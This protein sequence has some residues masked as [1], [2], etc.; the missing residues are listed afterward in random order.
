[1]FYAKVPGKTEGSYTVDH[2]A[3]S[4]VFDP[5]GRVRL[6]VRYGSGAEALAARPEAAARRKPAE[7][8]ASPATRSGRLQG[9]SPA[10]PLH[11][12]SGRRE[13]LAHLL[14]RRHFDL[15]DALGADA[16]L[17]GQVVQRHAA[18]AVVVDLQPALLDDAA[19]AR[20]QRV[21]RLRD[22]VAGQPVAAARFEHA[23]RLA[24]CRRP[25]RRSARS[26]PRRRRSAARARR[27]R[28]TGGF[29][30]RALLRA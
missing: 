16:V 12:V 5:Q 21:E 3:G 17:G 30:S 9:R 15:A 10:A 23:G 24:G 13:R 2:T 28:P 26:S 18:R 4:Y 14:H 27:R 1:M 6:F 22:A 8:S 19:A 29:P 11:G 25:G 7:P 20:V